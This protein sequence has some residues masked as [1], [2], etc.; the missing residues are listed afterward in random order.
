VAKITRRSNVTFLLLRKEVAPMHHG[1]MA[2]HDN[3]DLGTRILP[4]VD[5][6][7][8]VQLMLALVI[9]AVVAAALVV[10]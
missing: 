9:V 3:T 7:L 6:A 1:F 5:L 8:W 4:G 2:H 10:R